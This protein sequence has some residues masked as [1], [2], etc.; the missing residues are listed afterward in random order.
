M[1]TTI[2][3]KSESP[4][5]DQRLTIDTPTVN[6]A[7]EIWTL[8]RAS[9][10]LDVNSQYAYLLMCDHFAET[11]LIARRGSETL[12]FV[13]AYRPPTKQEVVFVWQIA[14]SEQAR[15][16]GLGRTLLRTLLKR[17]AAHGVKYLE[18]TVTPTNHSSAKL[19]EGLA[20]SMGAPFKKTLGFGPDLFAAQTHEAEVLY[21][22]G[23]LGDPK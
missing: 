12:G 17:M 19:F 2:D 18:A 7:A 3:M 20:R 14:V 22:I 5:V 6:D 8:V 4:S 13:I 23:P 11:C 16:Q 10:V 21:R 15:G 9:R 1:G